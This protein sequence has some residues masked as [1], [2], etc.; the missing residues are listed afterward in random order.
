MHVAFLEWLPSNTILGHFQNS[1]KCESM[2]V[3]FLQ[4]HSHFQGPPEEGCL[5]QKKL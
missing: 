4:K 5:H 3:I 2:E 1:A